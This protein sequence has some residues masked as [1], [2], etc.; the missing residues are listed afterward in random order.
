MPCTYW[1]CQC[2][3]PVPL[4][5]TGSAVGIF[6]LQWLS[7]WDFQ[8]PVAQRLE[9]SGSSGSAVGIF[10]LQ[11]LSGWDFQAPV[12]QRLG[13]SGSSGSAV[14]IFRLQWLSGWDFQAPVAQRLG[15][16]GG[17][18]CLFMQSHHGLRGHSGAF[19]Q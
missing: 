17:R 11:W 6:R 4:V 5:P 10:R 16:S 3:I 14:G 19:P 15:F 13:F 12:A 8:A 7:G 18:H 2:E 9:F 1:V